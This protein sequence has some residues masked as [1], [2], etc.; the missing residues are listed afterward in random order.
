MRVVIT[1]TMLLGV[2]TL[3]GAKLNIIWNETRDVAN[4]D[5]PFGIAVDSSKERCIYVAGKADSGS[6][7]SQTLKYSDNGIYQWIKPFTASPTEACDV[8]ALQDFAYVVGYRFNGENNDLL[9]VKYGS[10]G[11]TVWSRRYDT[12]INEQATGAAVDGMNLY[13]TGFTSDLTGTNANFLTMKYT[14]DGDTV[15]TRTYN[16][17]GYDV[18]NAITIDEDNVYVAGYTQNNTTDDFRVI[19]YS[20]QGSLQWNRTYDSG[21]DDEAQGIAVDNVGCIYVTGKASLSNIGDFYTVKIDDD[22]DLIWSKF[23]STP[24]DEGAQG[25]SFYKSRIYV[26]G[27][28][29]N[30]NDCDFLTIRYNPG[31]DSVWTSRY[32]SGDDDIAYDITTNSNYIYLTGI[33]DN[34]I[35]SDFRVMKLEE[36]EVQL[37][38]PNGSE[39]LVIGSKYDIKWNWISDID[40]VLLEFRNESTGDLDTVGVVPNTGAYSWTVPNKPGYLTKAFVSDPTDYLEV[41]DSS[42][43]YF[44]IASTGLE[45]AAPSAATNL[46]VEQDASNQVLIHYVI[47]NTSSNPQLRIFS[48]DGR[49][50]NDLTHKML[51]SKGTISWN[52]RDSKGDIM[53]KGVYFIE[54][55]ATGYSCTAKVVKIQ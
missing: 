44:T 2:S 38:L 4:N 43:S 28:S 35:N 45:E 23:Y 1:L 50:L 15:W 48:A 31:G 46:F 26:T 6:S 27:Y 24:N 19:K 41:R 14:L 33:Y 53:A 32:D 49:M 37:S 55:N 21:K 29:K 16:V 36:K 10:N 9:V 7:S 52:F 51:A 40:S 3:F 54:L 34:G 22:G 8:A 25:V 12:G 5:C 42:D 39:Q 20:K 18:S 11:D 13:V 30:Q 17:L 47:A